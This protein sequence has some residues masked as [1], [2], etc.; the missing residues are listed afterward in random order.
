[1]GLP[2]SRLTLGGRPILAYLLERLAW[3][4]PTLLVS[5]PGNERPPG[6]E[7]FGAEATDP[8]ADQGPLRGVLTA[9]ERASAGTD[10]VVIVTVDMPAM[11]RGCLEWMIDRLGP[12]MTAVMCSRSVEGVER[13]EPFPC[14]MRA[15]GK[16]MI[17]RRLGAGL[18]SVHGLCEET[19]VKVFPAPADWPARV[20]ANLNYPDDLAAFERT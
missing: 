16:Q 10:V 14:V 20:W 17:T 1:M 18:R 5:S 8:Q 6:H 12:G 13:V 9:L 15:S 3:P 7:L 4:G 19:G 11:E 2:K